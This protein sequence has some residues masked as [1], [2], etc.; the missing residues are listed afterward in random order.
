MRSAFLLLSLATIACGG[1]RQPPPSTAPVRNDS[2]PIRAAK[3]DTASPATGAL[4]A[5]ANQAAAAVDTI[6]VRPDSIVLRVGQTVEPTSILTIEAR[7]LA[8]EPI[9]GFAPF[10]EVQDRSVAEYGT[11]G[12]VG[13]SVG[14][15]MLVFSP[16]SLDP[17]VK[18]RPV[19]AVV[20]IRVVP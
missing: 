7:N 2:A 1:A 5:R 11:S 9:N 19:R 15:T 10:V 14:R 4:F 17:N 8:G 12:L 16:L 6:V 13:R 18:V 20:T 3:V